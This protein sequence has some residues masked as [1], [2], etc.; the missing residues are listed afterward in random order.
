LAFGVPEHQTGNAKK[1]SEGPSLKALFAFLQAKPGKFRPFSEQG[2]SM[3]PTGLGLDCYGVSHRRQ[4][5]GALEI[6][7]IRTGPLVV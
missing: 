5:A 2:S 7:Q 6:F 1:R 3:S 4:G